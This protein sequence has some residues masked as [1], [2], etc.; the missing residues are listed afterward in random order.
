MQEP[1]AEALMQ[2][3]L[4]WGCS[5]TLS[6][7]TGHGSKSQPPSRKHLDGLERVNEDGG[8][9]QGPFVEAMLQRIL[10]LEV[11][12]AQHTVHGARRVGLVGG[13]TAGSAAPVVEHAQVFIVPM[14]LGWR[15]V[16]G[17]PTMLADMQSTSRRQH[18]M[19]QACGGT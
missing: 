3:P 18:S 15:Q 8:G 13:A 10:I 14:G 16:E 12:L 17:C 7:H 9:V 4:H 1:L 11:L 2:C 5:L 19:P 6:Q